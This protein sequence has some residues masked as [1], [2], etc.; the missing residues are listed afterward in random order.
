MADEPFPKIGHFKDVPSFQQQLTALDLDVPCDDTI[1]SAA[2]GSPLAQPLD[3]GGFTVGNRWCIHPMEGWDGTPNGEPSDRTLRRWE[4]FGQSGAKL[5][6]GGEAFAVQGDGRANPLQIGVADNDAARAERGLNALLTRLT[7]AHRGRF[8]RADDL[9]VG[10][11]LTHS[12]RFSRPHDNFRLEPKIAY[13]HPMLDR[14]FGISPGSDAV[15]I[16]DDYIERLVCNYVR[17][18]Q[19]A[20]RVGFQFV[21]VKHCHGYLGH[22]LLSAFTRSGR[23]GG[24]FENRT[25]FAREIIT[26]IRAECPGLMIGVR[27]SAVDH[28]PFKPDPARSGDG[29]LGP[30]IPEP[31][32]LHLP[33]RYGFGCDQQNPLLPDLRE[34]VDFIRMLATLGVKLINV[35]CC[36]P[37]YNPHFQRPAM[38]PPSDGYQPPEDPLIGV[39]RQ[40]DLVR[41]L[42]TACHDS[43]F[44]GSAYT[45]LQEYL[46]HVAQAVVRKGWTDF[47]GLGRLALSYWDLP[48][49]TLAGAKL[50]AKHLCRTFSDCTTAPRNGI[51]SGCY[52]L[53]PHYKEA[54]EHGQLKAKK[55]ELRRKLS[56]LQR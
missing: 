32:Q 46:P 27:L 7:E 37:Y 25:R 28:P 22:E 38:F 4:H 42:K 51:I 40:I 47:V 12:G 34:P 41:Q 5:I 17:A 43:F 52:P 19:I 20:Q 1:L 15:V 16:S 10:L 39:A 23:Y 18:A 36:S 45:Y 21:D 11:Q 30:G 13:H 49:D 35:S 26:G 56:V 48:A 8:G 54:P 29:R 53:D 31:F 2:D 6:W 50:K 14:K 55:A 3:L 9:L 24:S 33:Y 44:V